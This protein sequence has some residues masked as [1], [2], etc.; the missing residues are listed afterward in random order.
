MGRNI[1]S[2]LSYLGVEAKNPP[3]IHIDDRAPTTSDYKNF[4]VTNLWFDKVAESLHIMTFRGYNATSG[5]NEGRWA[6]L[7]NSGSVTFTDATIIPGNLTITDGDINMPLGDINLTDGS[8]YLTNGDI[9]IENGYL[10]L[11]TSEGVLVS[12]GTGSITSSNGIVDYVLTS[13]GPGSIPTWQ[14]NSSASLTFEADDSNVI[15]PTAG[16][17]V[18]IFGGLNTNTTGVINNRIT[19]NAESSPVTNLTINEQTG[20]AYTLVA[21]DASKELRFTNAAAITLTIPL[22]SGV[23]FPIGTEFILVQYG[24]GTVTVVGAGG[25]TL[26]SASSMTDLYEQYSSAAL[27]K[28]ALDQWLL[29]GDIK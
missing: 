22:E 15:S 10:T 19:I 11:S 3:D 6:L 2:P 29:V 25:V 16:G 9:T 5:L 20:T 27:I 4:E 8:I 21:S 13:T 24:A 12:N 18:E 1:Y 28:Q 26:Y 17:L 7:G 23:N 14:E